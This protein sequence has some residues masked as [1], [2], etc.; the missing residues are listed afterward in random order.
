MAVVESSGT[1]TASIGTEHTVFTVATGYK[2]RTF[3]VDVGALAATE[4]LE[5]RVYSPVI[6]AGAV[7]LARLV[8]FTGTVSE[9][10]TQGLPFLVQPTGFFTIKQTSGTGRSFPWTVNTLD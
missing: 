2:T 9:P 10:N 3:N 5:V 1:Q 8:T 4:V 6:A 7:Q